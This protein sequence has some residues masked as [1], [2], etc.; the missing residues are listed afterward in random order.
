MEVLHQF[1]RNHRP[2]F[3]GGFWQSTR[4][5]CIDNRL[6]RTRVSTEFRHEGGVLV[7]N[8]RDI[9]GDLARGVG[10][11]VVAVHVAGGVACVLAVVTRGQ[12]DGVV[13]FAGGVER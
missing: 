2:F 3:F 1:L 11:T 9:A 7:V 5:V 8:A 12:R 6:D 13:V 4:V 10:V